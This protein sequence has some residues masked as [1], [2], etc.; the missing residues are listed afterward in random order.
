VF[1]FALHSQSFAR[2]TKRNAFAFALHW[3]SSARGVKPGLRTAKASTAA[4]PILIV[5]NIPLFPLC[6]VSQTAAPSDAAS[7][8][9]QL[10]GEEKS[11]DFARNATWRNASNTNKAWLAAESLRSLLCQELTDPQSMSSSLQL[12]LSMLPTFFAHY[13]HAHDLVF[14]LGRP[15]PTV[16]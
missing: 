7:K 12:P 16:P 13:R 15:A 14:R 5:V 11:S 2:G 6:Q 9:V 8:P 3:Q 4:Q 1:A 10:L